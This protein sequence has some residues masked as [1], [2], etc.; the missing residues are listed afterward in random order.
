MVL[1]NFYVEF[2]F[3][4]TTIFHLFMRAISASVLIF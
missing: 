3:H 4:S 1:Y 2:Y